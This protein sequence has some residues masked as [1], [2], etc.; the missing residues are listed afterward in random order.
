MPTLS[1]ADGFYVGSGVID[2]MY[3]GSNEV[4]TSS[5]PST[6]VEP[7]EVYSQE[8]V[9]N[10][11]LSDTI[12]I[13]G[14]T[15]ISG[16]AYMLIAITA[17]QTSPGPIVGLPSGWGTWNQ[18]TNSVYGARRTF[19]AWTILSDG[20]PGDI[21]IALSG[22]SALQDATVKLI[23]F[24][25]VNQANYLQNYQRFSYVN[26]NTA[27]T[28]RGLGSTVGN[29][30]VSVL[31]QERSDVGTA[32]PD[33]TYQMIGSPLVSTNGRVLYAAYSINTSGSLANATW[34]WPTSCYAAVFI[35]EIIVA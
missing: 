6:N 35:Q 8:Q 3:L 34:T 11:T 4:Y 5:V 22:G 9:L 31:A 26:T 10:N 28:D 12:D 7:F 23:R 29:I 17:V 24:T 14:V 33:G 1:S 18:L 13:T 20:T 2:K 30:A 27:A 19:S 32:T 15:P 25:N 16:D 21:T